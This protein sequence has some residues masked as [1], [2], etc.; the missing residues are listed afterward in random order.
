MF[1]SIADPRSTT[2]THTDTGRHT[3]SN[4]FSFVARETSVHSPMRRN[5]LKKIKKNTQNNT[6]QEHVTHECAAASA[7]TTQLKYI[8]M[9]K[10]QIHAYT[11][12]KYTAHNNHITPHDKNK[13]NHTK[14]HTVAWEAR[15]HSHT[16]KNHPKKNAHKTNINTQFVKLAHRTTGR[17]RKRQQT[18][19]HDTQN[20]QKHLHNT[21]NSRE[22]NTQYQKP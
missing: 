3:H 11:K 19:I 10:N 6:K 14:Q 18:Q 13:T 4:L 21:Y 15:I 7:K 1:V 20:S 17:M 5:N 16:R 2:D 22:K 8:H 12:I 9:Y